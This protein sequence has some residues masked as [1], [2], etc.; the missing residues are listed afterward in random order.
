MITKNG[1]R[2]KASWLFSDLNAMNLNHCAKFIAST[3]NYATFPAQKRKTNGGQPEL[4]III[5]FNKPEN[6]QE[7]YKKRWQIE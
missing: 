6:A 1:K 2:V 4:Q 5:S 3:G 7:I